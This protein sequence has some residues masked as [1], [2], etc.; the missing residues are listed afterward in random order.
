M[1]SAP[2][3]LLLRHTLVAAARARQHLH[4]LPLWPLVHHVWQPISSG[5]R[6]SNC[7]HIHLTSSP[8]LQCE[9]V[10][11]LFAYTPLRLPNGLRHSL[12]VLKR[13]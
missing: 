4:T 13:T 3:H 10:R 5:L 9:H 6:T 2:L 12:I 8:V 11:S 1:I 7:T